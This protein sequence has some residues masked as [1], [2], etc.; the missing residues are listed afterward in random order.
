MQLSELSVLANMPI[1]SIKFNLRE[2]LLP[3]GELLTAKRADYG[4]RHLRRIHTIQTLRAVNG[5]RISQIRRIVAMIDSGASR[6]EIL[7]ALQLEIQLHGD[8]EAGHTEAGDVVVRRRG[9]PD[10]PSAARRA[11]DEHLGEMERLGVAPSP[12][13]LEVY[14][15]AVGQR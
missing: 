1:A 10:V 4:E 12:E 8:V 15:R 3:S 5:L 6:I 11:L 14:S 7:T 9:W 2:G 13:V